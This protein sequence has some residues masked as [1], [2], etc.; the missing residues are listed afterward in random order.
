MARTLLLVALMKTTLARAAL[1]AGVVCLGCG[2]HGRDAGD[3]VGGGAA[4]LSK[5]GGKTGP[6]GQ[7][8]PY[9]AGAPFLGAQAPPPSADAASCSLVLTATVRDFD[10]S[11]PDFERFAGDA[12]YPGLVK[13]LLG[14]DAKPA[15]AHAGPTP[16]TSG[17]EAFL[18]WYNDTPGVNQTFA[19]E[20][21][22]EE[23][24]PGV[25]GF[26][27]Q[28]FFPVDGVGFGDSGQDLEGEDHNFHFTTEVHTEF[29]Y[30][31][32][33]V[34]T[35]QG[36]DDMW[37]FVNGKLAIDLGGL[38]PEQTANLD[39]DAA[40][41]QLAI[42]VGNTY[43]MDIFHAERHT[44]ASNFYLETTIGCFQTPAAPK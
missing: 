2:S 42:E 29:P 39:L 21:E 15:Y 30:E 19:V 12:A 13:D 6:D 28:G 1:F 26:G 17:P 4:V 16:Q 14:Q 5:D 37:L 10:T 23:V 40:A 35:F 11:H 20:L 32:G 36:D 9:D 22:I 33:E 38:H 27:G 31:G 25:Y 41:G 34:F 8:V 43:T 44:E 24:R 7:A 18:Q 3:G